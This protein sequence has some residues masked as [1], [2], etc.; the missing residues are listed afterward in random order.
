MKAMAKISQQIFSLKSLP[1]EKIDTKKTQGSRSI[2]KKELYQTTYVSTN[3][4]DHIAT[5]TIPII[6][7]VCPPSSFLLLKCSLLHIRMQAQPSPVEPSPVECS[8][9]LLSLEVVNSC[10]WPDPATANRT[11]NVCRGLGNHRPSASGNR[12]RRPLLY[13]RKQRP[14]WSSRQFL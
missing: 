7:R 9:W 12:K 14:E 2:L 11:C 10:K 6:I 1:L 5:Q 3:K 4:I 8:P 13:W